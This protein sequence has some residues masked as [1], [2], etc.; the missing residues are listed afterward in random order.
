MEKISLSLSFLT[1]TL[2]RL[3][4]IVVKGHD[5]PDQYDSKQD[6]QQPCG[7]FLFHAMCVILT[8]H[9]FLMIQ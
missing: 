9:V 4:I 1:Q 7:I 8:F 3:I 2:T 6:N 5:S